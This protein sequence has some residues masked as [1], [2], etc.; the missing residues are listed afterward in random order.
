MTNKYKKIRLNKT[1]TIDEHRHI[2]QVHLGRKL[3]REE[4]V[5][6]KN[7]N[8]RDNRLENLE[9][10]PLSEHARLHKKGITGVIHYNKWRFRDGNYW[11]NKCKTYL[12]KENFHKCHSKKYGII[13]H[14]KKC[15]NPY[16]IKIRTEKRKL[17]VA[18]K[19]EQAAVARTI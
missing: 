4:T 6:H 17:L 5:H 8:P 12:P 11:C 15:I 1:E 19:S 2:M 18:Q 10:L 7:G 13:V 16:L 14:C 3:S 9:V